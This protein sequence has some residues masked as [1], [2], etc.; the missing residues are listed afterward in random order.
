MTTQDHGKSQLQAKV[1]K[2]ETELQNVKRESLNEVKKFQA[3]NYVLINQNYGL[4]NKLKKQ[5]YKYELSQEYFGWAVDKIQGGRCMDLI[6]EVTGDICNLDDM[7]QFFS[8]I[9]VSGPVYRHQ[10]Q[11]FYH[12]I[13]HSTTSN[14]LENIA[15]LGKHC[16]EKLDKDEALEQCDEI[17]DCYDDEESK[18][19]VEAAKVVKEDIEKNW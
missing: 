8:A 16:G 5:A 13:R 3:L 10:Y 15:K 2:L 1:K 14:V 7:E 12:V 9:D 4:E 17:I 19:F 6:D 11:L 18:E